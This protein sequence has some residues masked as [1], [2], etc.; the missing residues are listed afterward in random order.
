MVTGNA[1][2]AFPSCDMVSLELIFRG[3]YPIIAKE[4]KGVEDMEEP[5][6]D[7][8]HDRWQDNGKDIVTDPWKNWFLRNQDARGRR[9]Y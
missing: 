8:V 7:G 3:M 2:E 5:S 4:V 1:S 6:S 9:R